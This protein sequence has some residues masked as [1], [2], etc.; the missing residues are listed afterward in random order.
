MITTA[1]AA[2]AQQIQEITENAGVFNQEEIECVGEIFSEYVTDG[3][4]VSGY[5]FMVER[6]GERVLGF[7]CYGWRD[8]TDGVY[9]LFWIAVAPDARRKGTGRRLLLA[10]EDAVCKRGGRMLIAETSGTPLYE[11]TRKFYLGS[12]YVNEATIRDFYSVGDDLKVYV[13]RL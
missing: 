12:G 6:E 3:A 1:T 8:L 4:E 5:H 10:C 7:A 2:D 9:D 13:K 11:S